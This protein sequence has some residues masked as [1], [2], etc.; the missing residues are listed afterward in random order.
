[1]PV[2]YLK[3]QDVSA[4]I[5]RGIGTLRNDRYHGRGLPYI[6]FGRHVRYEEKDVIQF[7]QECKVQTDDS[8][9]LRDCE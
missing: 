6:K 5:G 1:M 7:M 3:E 4:L 2:K 9:G 8:R